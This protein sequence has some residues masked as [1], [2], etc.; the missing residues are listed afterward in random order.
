MQSHRDSDFQPRSPVAQQFM[1]DLEARAKQVSANSGSS[2][3]VGADGEKPL[4]E[5]KANGVHVCHLPDDVLGILRIS[6][7]GG[8]H[9]PVPLSYLVFRGDRSL[10]INLLR[11]ALKALETDPK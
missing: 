6:I 2:I 9:M 5:W 1:R 8:D 11:K 3:T 7:G 10:C 4:K